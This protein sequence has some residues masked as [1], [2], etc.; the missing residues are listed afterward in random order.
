MGNIFCCLFRL[1]A[2]E[3]DANPAVIPPSTLAPSNATSVLTTRTDSRGVPVLKPG[4]GKPE[5]AEA[6][7]SLEQPMRISTR[8]PLEPVS[9]TRTDSRGVPVL[10]PGSGKPEAAEAWASLEQS[11]ATAPSLEVFMSRLL[12]EASRK[13][14]ELGCI[15]GDGTP[16]GTR[17]SLTEAEED[18]LFEVGL[19]TGH[20]NALV[21]FGVIERAG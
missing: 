16:A 10:K 5:A 19:K 6:W 11:T 2:A 7:A 1:H 12:P 13:L 15:K 4:S 14:R 3:Q 8:I 21:N 20:L 9:E 18:A 17:V